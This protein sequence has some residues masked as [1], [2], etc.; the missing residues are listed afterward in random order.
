M[1][2]AFVYTLI[3]RVFEKVL[4]PHAHILVARLRYLQDSALVS[5]RLWPQ[6]VRVAELLF[7]ELDLDPDR[8]CILSNLALESLIW[9]V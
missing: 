6:V 9:I 4:S 1:A 2:V 8:H 3:A 7:A 5:P